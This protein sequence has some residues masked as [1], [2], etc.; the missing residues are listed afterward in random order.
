M[1]L[2]CRGAVYFINVE[3]GTSLDRREEEAAVS[4]LSRCA[5]PVRGSRAVAEQRKDREAARQDC[6]L[7]W[8]K[9]LL[10]L[11]PPRAV[12]GGTGGGG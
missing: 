2:G 8:E 1:L 9:M 4:R 7:V 11:L 3:S 10:L 6:L 12:C 5:L